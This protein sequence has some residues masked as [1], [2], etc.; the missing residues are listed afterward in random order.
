MALSLEQLVGHWRRRDADEAESTL[1][2]R[3]EF[4]PDG[5][6]IAHSQ[7]RRSDWD[8][9]AFDIVGTEQLRVQ[10]AWD[11]NAH[12]TVMLDGDDLLIGDGEHRIA[13]V[14]DK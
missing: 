8:E 4:R 7:G 14:R 1:P 6:Y 2:E 3:V 12:Y 5:T 11:G 10:T 9:A 13:F